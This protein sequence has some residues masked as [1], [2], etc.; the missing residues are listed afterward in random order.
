MTA[1]WFVFLT[2][3]GLI[4]AFVPRANADFHDSVV[5]VWLFDEGAGST[6]MDAVNDHHG[7]LLGAVS[8]TDEAMFG[9]ALEF[10]GERGNRVEVPDA[11]DLTLDTWTITAWVKLNP[12]IESTDGW[13]IVLVKDPANGFQNYSLD[14][15]GA[16]Q[17]VSEV[18]SG[19]SWSNCVSTTSVHDDEWHF[20]AASYDG[21]ILRAYVDGVL[22]CE[23]QFGPG[24]QNDATLSIGDRLNDSQPIYGIIDDVGLFNIDLDENDLAA[25]MEKGL[26]EAL[27]LG[28]AFL[29]AGDADQDLDFDQLDLVKVQIAA[30]YLT[31]L[32]ATW[33]E[34]DWDGAPGGSQGNPPA[35]NM[36][37]DQLDIIAALAPAH[38]LK[39]PYSAVRPGGR[40]GDGQTSV[41]YNPTTGELFVDAPAGTQL[42]SINIDSA[43]RIFTG[44]AAQNLGGSFDNDS[45]NNI[46]KATFGSSFGSLSFGNVAQP[47][48]SQD[49]LLGDLTVVG[50]LAGGGALGDV[51]LIYIPEPSSLALSA[52]GV[53]AVTWVLRLRRTATT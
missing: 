32:A 2:S 25:I 37:F 1:K 19:G 43:T 10:A 8:W 15:N 29:Q 53:L 31:G 44:A 16:G 3:V 12:P 21:D 39:G 46:F 49:L 35:G 27:S 48:L 51:D 34:G 5:A 13:T 50:S 6:T 36:R 52:I 42:T 18:T 17:V 41:G 23:Q 45:D 7:E 30:K 40:Q 9:K 14:M 22:E 4:G 26:R 38:Y 24:D 20:T 47:G 11:P 28:A 33:G